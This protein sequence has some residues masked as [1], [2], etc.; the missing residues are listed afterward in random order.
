M[1]HITVDYSVQLDAVFDRRAFAE[2]L[3]PL[4]VGAVDSP[5]V[6]K[7]FFRPA[8]ETFVGGREEAA[9]VHVDIGL[10]RGRPDGRKARLSEAVLA[11]LDAY[12]PDEP[13]GGPVRSVE[14]RDLALSYR[15]RGQ[16]AHTVTRYPHNPDACAAAAAAPTRP[17]SEPSR[18]GTI[19]TPPVKDNVA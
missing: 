19:S 8:A 17:A 15:L 10:L 12:L 16:R 7:I 13:D 18:A 9:F 4:V 6:C 3:H 5:G 2:E 14:V 11:L 1:P